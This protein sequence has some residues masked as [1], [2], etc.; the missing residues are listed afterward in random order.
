M[1]RSGE[2]RQRIVV[3]QNKGRRDGAKID[4]K[5]PRAGPA[6][7]HRMQ[8]KQART[9][10]NSRAQP[11]NHQIDEDESKKDDGAPLKRGR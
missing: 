4:G 11:K 5:R 9:E 1:A 7:D 8:M 2:Y 10:A 3:A 6:T